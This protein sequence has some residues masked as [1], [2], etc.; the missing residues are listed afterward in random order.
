VAGNQALVALGADLRRLG[1]QLPTIAVVAATFATLMALAT[2]APYDYPTSDVSA[3]L[4]V[5]V[6]VVVVSGRIASALLRA[7][8]T[9]GEQANATARRERAAAPLVWVLLVMLLC[10]WAAIVLGVSAIA[11]SPAALDTS[12][13]YA[14]ALR[15]LWRVG[16][17]TLWCVIFAVEYVAA[18][19][20][21]RHRSRVA[22]ELRQLWVR[23]ESE[24]HRLASDAIA[25]GRRG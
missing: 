4:A 6:A 21:W 16:V 7:A 14:W 23:I 8:A 18:L 12:W 20:A 2:R 19:L 17:A 3:A 1:V 5:L 24:L 15:N 22:V 9:Q 10:G 13:A 11:Y 25:T